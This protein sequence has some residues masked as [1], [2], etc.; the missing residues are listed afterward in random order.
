M[1]K[2]LSIAQTKQL[3]DVVRATIITK[4]VNAGQRKDAT[5]SA[6][7]FDRRSFSGLASKGLVTHADHG[8][9]RWIATP[10]G[11]AVWKKSI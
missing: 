8:F 9:D 1:A 2:Q 11:Y 6:E 4:G 10:E 5:I 3:D 7:H